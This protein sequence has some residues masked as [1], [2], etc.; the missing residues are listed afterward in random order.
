MRLRP[1]IRSWPTGTL[2]SLA[3]LECGTTFASRPGTATYT[4]G[5]ARSSGSR[6]EPS[7]RGSAQGIA[8]GH[9]CGVAE[10]DALRSTRFPPAVVPIQREDPDPPRGAK[11]PSR[12]FFLKRSSSLPRRSRK[13]N[14]LP[15]LLAPVEPGWPSGQRRQTQDLLSKEF[16]GSNP[17]PGIRTIRNTLARSARAAAPSVLDKR[18]RRL[19]EPSLPGPPSQPAL[20]AQGP[21]PSPGPHARQSDS[22]ASDR[23][24]PAP[25]VA[26]DRTPRATHDSGLSGRFSGGSR[27]RSG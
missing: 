19:P 11:A 8:C 2:S 7:G 20:F 18:G 23:T 14:N 13:K 17:G 3:E 16:P 4:V 24:F 25:P 6:V 10:P 1:A 22:R 15:R 21:E 12:C 5:V 26:P 27:T 9:V